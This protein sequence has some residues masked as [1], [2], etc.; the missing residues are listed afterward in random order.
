[1]H[2]IKS[3]DMNN[4]W[5]KVFAEFPVLHREFLFGLQR[6]NVP[7]PQPYMVETPGNGLGGYGP[8]YRSRPSP[9]ALSAAARAK[10]EPQQQAGHVPKFGLSKKSGE[11]KRSGSVKK[12]DV[13]Q[14]VIKQEEQ[15]SPLSRMPFASESKNG[16]FADPTPAATSTQPQS[17]FAI[18]ITTQNQHNPGRTAPASTQRHSRSATPI[19]T[20]NQ[21]YPGSVPDLSKKRSASPLLVHNNPK[22]QR[23][24]PKSA[25]EVEN[26]DMKK[27]EEEKSATATITATTQPGVGEKETAM[28]HDKEKGQMQNSSAEDVDAKSN[29]K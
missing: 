17:Q 2:V 12:K 24:L 10:K 20:P 8:T 13:P 29:S 27:S 5:M 4:A 19:T 26:L 28:S 22:L 11:S 9:A 15:S 21:E 7:L 16:R 25:A 23:L 6:K 3:V 14:L 1:M 18:P